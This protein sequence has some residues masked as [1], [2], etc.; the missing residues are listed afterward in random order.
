MK[1]DVRVI[2]T[3][4][5]RRPITLT[6]YSYANDSAVFATSDLDPEPEDGD[7]RKKPVNRAIL[8]VPQATAAVFQNNP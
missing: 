8:S 7:L 5:D 6:E 2:Q 3:D 1:K 4:G